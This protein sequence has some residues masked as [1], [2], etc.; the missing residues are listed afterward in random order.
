MTQTSKR[1]L[2]LLGLA[3]ALALALAGCRARGPVAGGQ[4]PDP[5][6]GSWER[7]AGATK[8]VWVFRP[9]GTSGYDVSDLEA[10]LRARMGGRPLPA[11][12]R[13]FLE[14]ERAKVFTWKREGP[15]YRLEGPDFHQTR[16]GRVVFVKV[17]GDRMSLTSPDGA[18]GVAGQEFSR[19]R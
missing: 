5:I 7:P 3:L 12:A 19:V 9:D 2:A 11:R 8:L 13:Q 16:L 15:V 10:R 1:R 17:Q 14:A 18:A 6:V 4:A